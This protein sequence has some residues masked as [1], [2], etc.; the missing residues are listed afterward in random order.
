M[1]QFSRSI[2]ALVLA[3]LAL[4]GCAKD[5]AIGLSPNIEVTNLTELPPPTILEPITV[6]AHDKLDVTVLHSEVLSGSYVTDERGGLVFPLIGRVQ[7]F[8]LTPRR[9]A[10]QLEDELRG[11]YLVDPHVTVTPTNVVQP[12]VSVGGSVGKPGSYPA[13]TSTS[14]LRTINNAGGLT[15]FADADDVLV[16]RTSSGQRYI[17]VFNLSA[18]QRGNYDDPEIYAGD[19]VIVGDSPQRRRLA[20]IL[21]IAPIVTSGL[22][23]LERAFNN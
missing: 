17:G 23:L 4:G 8:G 22:V 11:R 20:A 16:M 5:R 14:L 2:T 3:M 7:A 1:Q 10:E 15:E 21:Q 9:V 13:T 18:I 12:S 6:G 19:T